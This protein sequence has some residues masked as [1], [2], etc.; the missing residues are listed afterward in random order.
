MAISLSTSHALRKL[1]PPEARIRPELLD[2]EAA[3]C[4]DYCGLWT[5]I[6]SPKLYDSKSWEHPWKSM[7][8]DDVQSMKIIRR[9]IYDN[10]VIVCLGFLDRLRLDSESRGSSEEGGEN[11]VPGETDEESQDQLAVARGGAAGS[12]SASMSPPKRKSADGATFGAL[13]EFLKMFLPSVRTLQACW[14]HSPRDCVSLIFV[15]AQNLEFFERWKTELIDRLMDKAM[16]YP[17]ESGL[18]DLL[19]VVFRVIHQN[20]MSLDMTSVQRMQVGHVR[21]DGSLLIVK[22]EIYTSRPP[23]GFCPYARSHRLLSTRMSFRVAECQ[24]LLVVQE[25]GSLHSR[26]AFL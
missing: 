16:Q 24:R 18:Y 2:G 20:V 9:S 17:H 21:S 10:V 3:I 22:L 8:G 19:A 11:E 7:V 26:D 6:T 1:L 23:D 14:P 25:T 5:A 12:V 13:V 4:R 15:G